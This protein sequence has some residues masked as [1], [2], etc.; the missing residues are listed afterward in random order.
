MDCIWFSDTLSSW[1]IKAFLVALYNPISQ[2]CVTKLRSTALWALQQTCS[3]MHHRSFAVVSLLFCN[4]H[5][6]KLQLSFCFLYLYFANHW[7]LLGHCLVRSAASW[8]R[9][10]EGSICVNMH[11]VLLKWANYLR[12][13][14]RDWA[15]H[16]HLYGLLCITIWYYLTCFMM[17]ALAL[18]MANFT[19]VVWTQIKYVIF[20]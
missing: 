17:I 11:F 2:G 6:C 18:Y 5:L 10:L 14:S 13:I 7:K 12:C 1:C 9:F 20:L 16:A 15:V 4:R 8:M 3:D 19:V